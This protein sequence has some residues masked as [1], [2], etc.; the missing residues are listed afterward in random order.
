MLT[1]AGKRPEAAWVTALL[2]TC[3]ADQGDSESARAQFRT[4]RGLAGEVGS[5]PLSAAI[6]VL[7]AAVDIARARSLALTGD[8]SA[9]T[10]ASSGRG[11]LWGEVRDSEAR[12]SGRAARSSLHCWPRFR[13]LLH[14]GLR[15]RFLRRRTDDRL[16]N[17]SGVGDRGAALQRL[18][19]V[20]AQRG[21]A[22]GLKR[23]QV[24]P[25]PL[26][27]AKDGPIARGRALGDTIDPLEMH[28]DRGARPQL[29]L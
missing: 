14:R 8:H 1:E 20:G 11:D 22:S 19:S 2:A 18:A 10:D 17:L 7:T 27:R 5:A 29:S 26:A 23:N 28:D 21:V 24:P 12:S 25:K 16:P 15:V 4:A 9:R 13:L 6:D 3:D